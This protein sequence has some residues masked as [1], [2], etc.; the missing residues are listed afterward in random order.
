M[1]T[2]NNFEILRCLEKNGGHLITQRLVAEE[3]GFSTG[4]TNAV[5]NDLIIRGLVDE[6]YKLT[7]EGLEALAPYR[8]EDALIL[9]AGMA[10]RF[11]PYSL[12]KPK[13]LMVCKGEVL[14][15]RM[16]RQ[17]KEAGVK[18]IVVVVGYMMEQFLYLRDKY[19]VKFVVNNEYAEKNT[20]SSVWAARDYLSNTYICCAD[21]YYPSNPFNAYE[22]R[23]Y[24]CSIYL[25]GTS[26]VERALLFGPDGLI[27]STA[28]PSCDQWIMYGHA[29]FDREFTGK[30]KPI[31]E[32]YYGRPGV[33]QM[34][35]E[36]IYAENV[37][38]LPMYAKKCAG[39]EILEFD[40]ME[41]MRAFDPDFIAEN[42]SH[43][44][45]NICQTLVCKPEDVTD[46]E[47]MESGLNNRSF[48]FCCRGERYVYRHPGA[49]ASGVID[50]EKE[51]S[52]LLSAREAGVDRTLVH[53]DPRD[54]W[55]I[56]R[57]INVSET[58][59]FEDMRHVR[60]LAQKLRALHDGAGLIGH[61]FNYMEEA[62]R[63]IENI[64]RVDY[65]SYLKVLAERDAMGFIAERLCADR[66]P[67][68]LCHNDLYAPNLLVEGDELHLIDWEFAGD[69]DA[70]Y[71]ICKLFATK[72]RSD[73]E[74]NE[75]LKLYFG[76]DATCEERLH[77]VC[78]AALVYYYW[79]VWAVYA[80]KN[81]AEASGYLLYWYDQM[82]YYRDEAR[83]MINQQNK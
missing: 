35:W 74:L 3:C 37:S 62:D 47:K 77:L 25:P 18:E 52:A 57:F 59:D 78:C 65:S 17:L 58:F 42:P 54:G 19:S 8:V 80:G 56:S 31:L 5:L 21:N 15:E 28:K 55:K 73:E 26:Y 66:W 81:G 16:I 6:S 82:V 43:F 10:S 45:D 50:R 40:S 51:C 14:I 67:V 7:S 20:H 34:Y 49:N 22:Y 71:D 33:E 38:D 63:L 12:E 76:R 30:F 41:E 60:M 72:R 69:S 1:L 70:G 4:K 46:I 83:K 2:R 79:F 48:S 39:G 29:Y 36:T 64:R 32:D 11:F 23:P 68:V 61:P 53:V 44:L 24:Y 75:Y 9:A 27:R 13:G